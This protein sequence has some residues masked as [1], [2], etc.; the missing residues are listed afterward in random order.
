MT[1][2]TSA[3]SVFVS[4]L[5]L[6]SSSC[7]DDVRRPAKLLRRRLRRCP[8][9]LLGREVVV[10]GVVSIVSK[11]LLGDIMFNF[12][13]IALLSLVR[14]STPLPACTDKGGTNKLEFKLLR[15]EN[16]FVVRPRGRGDL[17][18]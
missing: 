17:R 4:P 2:G 13:S 7:S 8:E 3:P 18:L 6:P 10:S 9:R 11:L 12:S 16:L 1:A 5:A 15:R 14:F